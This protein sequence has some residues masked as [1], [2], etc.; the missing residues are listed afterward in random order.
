MTMPQFAVIGCGRMGRERAQHIANA[1]G[2]LIAVADVDRSRAETLALDHPA[3]SVHVRLQDI[4]WDRLDGVFVCTP[5]AMHAEAIE[6]AVASGIAVFAE[7]PLALDAAQAREVAGLV[8]GKHIANAVGYMN[9]ARKSVA[10]ARALLAGSQPIAFCAHWAGTRYRVPWWSNAEISGGA[11]NEQATHLVDLLRFLGGDVETVF[12]V[13]GRTPERTCVALRFESGAV[14][15]LLHTC[16]ARDKEI[17][18]VAITTTGVIR[19]SGWEFQISDNTIDRARAENNDPFAA[20]VRSFVQAV[21]TQ[22]PSGVA[23]DFDDAWK[24][25]LVV[26]RIRESAALARGGALV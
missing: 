23:C 6:L 26:D 13:D 9:R 12:A 1:G 18:V 24:T 10:V 15:T 14:A 4:P 7:K 11:F 16:E 17:G 22:N 21:S 2:A 5:P 25:Q 19:L 8:E 20:E 3:A